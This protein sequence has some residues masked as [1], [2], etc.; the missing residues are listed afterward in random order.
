ME[1]RRIASF[2][3]CSLLLA[4]T[5]ALAAPSSEPSSDQAVR[6]PYRGTYVCQ[7]LGAGRGILRVPIDLVI[8]NGNVEFARPLLN[9]NGTRIIGNEMASG[10]TDADSKIHLTSTWYNGGIIFHADYSGTL[11]PTGGTLTGTQTW[12][13]PRGLNGSRTCTAALVQLPVVNQSPPRQSLPN[14]L[15]SQQ[16]QQSLPDQSPAQQQ[17]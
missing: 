3:A 13:S 17:D 4:A 5:T 1:H 11:T 2:G 14:Q 7:S 16:P 15:P 9:W 8:R 12:H 6:G 10:T